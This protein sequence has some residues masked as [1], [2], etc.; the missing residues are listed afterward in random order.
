M[1]LMLELE[2][3]RGSLLARLTLATSAIHGALLT[4]GAWRAHVCPVCA[5]VGACSLGAHL[6]YR[7]DGGPPLRVTIGACLFGLCVGPLIPLTS[8]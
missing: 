6:L 7:M 5:V 1:I 2:G 4:Y 3:N 8:L